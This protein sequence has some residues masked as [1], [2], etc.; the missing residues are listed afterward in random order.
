MAEVD[1]GIVWLVTVV[2]A[3]MVMFAVVKIVSVAIVL[4]VVTVL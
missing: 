1:S 3:A 4:E 2:D